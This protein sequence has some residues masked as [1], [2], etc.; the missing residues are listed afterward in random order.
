MNYLIS[1]LVVVVTIIISVFLLSNILLSI[2]Y[3]IPRIR[4]EKKQN[5][6]TKRIPVYK[7]VT[8]IVIFSAIFGFG[9]YLVNTY[10]P[11]NRV[12]IYIGLAISL[13]LIIKRVRKKNSDMDEDFRRYFKDYLKSE[14]KNEESDFYVSPALLQNMKKR[15]IEKYVTK[16]FK[17]AIAI[18]DKILELNPRLHDAL[19]MRA[20]CLEVLNFNLDAIDDYE[21][22]FEIDD[23]D[24]NV[25]GLMGLLYSKIGQLE[26]AKYYLELSIA[27]GWKTYEV[28]LIALNNFS[29]DTLKVLQESRQKPENLLRRNRKD[30][31]DDLSEIDREEFNKNLFETIRCVNEGLSLDPENSKLKQLRDDFY[32]K[33]N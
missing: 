27:R 31:E 2:F 1:F 25:I 32:S 18:Y 28:N 26:K 21:A 6:L 16:D 19:I 12:E 22:A 14:R 9:F 30:F 7:I 3:T 17:N 11:K 10:L 29:E 24:G 15:A 8:P 4:I 23:S 5:N 33:L 20:Q 13:L